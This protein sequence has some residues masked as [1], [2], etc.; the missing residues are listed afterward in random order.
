MELLERYLQAIG[1]YLPVETRDDTLAELRANLLDTIEAKAEQ[2]ER[3]LTDAET[4]E[5]LRAH[6]KPEV[7]AL[8]YLPQR[9]LIGPSIYP[10]YMLTLRKVVPLVSFI[11][12]IVLAVKLIAHGNTPA[13]WAAMITQ[14]VLG[15]VPVLLLNAAIVTIVFAVI[16]SCHRDHK[17]KCGAET[18]DPT[19]LPPLKVADPTT[20][21]KS[22][23]VR[24]VELFV[25][26][27][28]M[29]Y[30][31]SIP[32]HPFWLIGPGTY[33]L[34]SLGVGFAPIWHVFY[35]WLVVLL[36]IQLVMKIAALLPG[37]HRWMKPLDLLMNLLGAIAIGMVAFARESLVATSSNTNLQKLAAVNHSMALAFRV[38][39]FFAVLGLAKEAWKYAKNWV[40][41]EKMVF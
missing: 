5:I 21:P 8:R 28:W 23:G 1:Q 32:W 17:A 37:S 25:H 30:A 4:G 31:L 11:F 2:L 38:A 19:K 24:L 13:E 27:L 16:E 33:Y 6:G 7:V 22:F 20:K 9:S 34:S 39:L 36:S 3:P 40:P 18:W 29:M 14:G 12:F 15:V 35:G 10:F 41:A 26:C